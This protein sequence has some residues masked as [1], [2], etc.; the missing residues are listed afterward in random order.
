MNTDTT[1][2][3]YTTGYS[4]LFVKILDKKVPFEL[5]RKYIMVLW[6]YTQDHQRGKAHEAIFDYMQ[7]DRWNENGE[8]YVSEIDHII[9][10][11]YVCCG[12]SVNRNN[13]CIGKCGTKMTMQMCLFN[14]EEYCKRKGLFDY[15]L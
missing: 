15:S 2:I 8:L 9:C 4:E 14:A 7:V 3:D 13:E 12:L 5:I 1:T 6:T 10:Y 11:A